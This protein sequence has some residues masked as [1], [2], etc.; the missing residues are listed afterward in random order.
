MNHKTYG[1]VQSVTPKPAQGQVA[2]WLK[3]HP[4]RAVTMDIPVHNCRVTQGDNLVVDAKDSE[5]TTRVLLLDEQYW[6]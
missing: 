6:K 4:S 3:S 2:E 5:G 1:E